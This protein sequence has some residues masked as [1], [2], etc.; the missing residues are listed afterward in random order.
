[1]ADLMSGQIAMGFLS[2]STVMP[3][4]KAGKLRV[5]GLIENRRFPTVP[6]VLTIGESLKGYGAPDTWF[7]M[8]GPANLPA[9]L[10]AR[11]N[12][13][14]R[15][16]LEAPEVRQR[17]EGIGFEVVR[18]TPQEFAASIRKDLELIQKTVAAAGIKPE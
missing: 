13:E 2:A 8:L 1:M 10:V 15:A 14:I 11:L 7:G 6:G 16:A 18:N 4:V 5:L 9:P 3:Q 17:M 12:G